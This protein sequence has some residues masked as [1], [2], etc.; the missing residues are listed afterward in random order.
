MNY[1]RNKMSNKG[2]LSNINMNQKPERPKFTDKSDKQNKSTGGFGNR[3]GMS[4]M[5]NDR[6]R[7]RP[8]GEEKKGFGHRTQNKEDGNKRSERRDGDRETG[9]K[10]QRGRDWYDSSEFCRTNRRTGE[11]QWKEEFWTNKEPDVRMHEP[12]RDDKR[13]VGFTVPTS[14]KFQNTQYG[15]YKCPSGKTF[16]YECAQQIS[17]KFYGIKNPTGWCSRDDPSTKQY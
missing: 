5:S 15:Q 14:W 4:G 17:S 12:K 2:A 16:A 8:N 13:G 3:M 9:L 7:D 1:H 6:Q 10:R 11:V